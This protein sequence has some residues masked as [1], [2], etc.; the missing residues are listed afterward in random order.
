M[1]A[2]AERTYGHGT[3]LLLAGPR[4]SVLLP[5]S[6][7][8]YLVPLW[9][10]VDGPADMDDL[11]EWLVD[12]G[13]RSFPTLLAIEHANSSGARLLLRG[14]AAITVEL[15]DG[16]TETHTGAERRTWLDVA[17]PDAVRLWTGDAAP[18]AADLPLRHGVVPAAGFA[19]L[20]DSAAAPAPA[21]QSPR[22]TSGTASTPPPTPGPQPAPTSTPSPAV[23]AAAAAAA[24]SRPP[25]PLPV[26]AADTDTA[27]DPG[28]DPAPTPPSEPTSPEPEAETPEA[29][30]P[31]AET[32]AAE[33]PG[34]GTPA[35]APFPDETVDPAAGITLVPPVL[36]AVP[37]DGDAD[38][39]D[40]ADAAVVIDS[41]DLPGLDLDGPDQFEQVFGA[42]RKSTVEHAAVRIEDEL[43]DAAPES[44]TAESERAPGGEP[45]DASAAGP[46]SADQG[47][48]DGRTISAAE[49][50]RLRGKARASAAPTPAPGAP[51][52]PGK[53][54][55]TLCGRHHPNPP[56]QVTC[57]VCGVALDDTALHTVDRPELGVLDFADGPRPVLEGTIIV[58]RSPKM[59]TTMQSDIPALVSVDSPEGGVSRSHLEVRVEGWSVSVVDL[60]STNGTQVTLPGEPPRRLRRGE[61]C[62]ITPGT[63]VVLGEEVFATYRV[64]P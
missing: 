54:R 51:T 38:S 56:N 4:L 64:E 45:A 22:A 36:D 47:D 60:G 24:S 15:P 61:P 41:V 9:N 1:N 46:A 49:L 50:A 6:S 48:H 23:A 33:T 40:V 57:R 11:V 55:A 8:E 19:M 5:K 52:A 63:E 62:L 42:T 13:F 37:A 3:D 14:S 31:E 58:G 25:E 44:D 16:A 12:Q 27:V 7:S 29:E 21:A 59:P 43:E 32:P 30:T 39:A 20:I 34:A 28:L 10:L 18:Q 17:I 53:V 2:S 26:P 35:T